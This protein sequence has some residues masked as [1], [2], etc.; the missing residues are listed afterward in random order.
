MSQLPRRVSHTGTQA[1]FVQV[2]EGV[3]AGVSHVRPH[4]PQFISSVCMFTQTPPQNV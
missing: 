3:P 2:F 4:T 1:P